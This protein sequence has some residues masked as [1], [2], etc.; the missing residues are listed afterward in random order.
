MNKRK[1]I[2][3]VILIF[4]IMIL[5]EA[6]YAYRNQWV[7]YSYFLNVA[8]FFN[9]N[10]GCTRCAFFII[11]QGKIEYPGDKQFED[12]VQNR[13]A[14]LPKEYN[15][16]AAI[17]SLALDAYE[18]GNAGLTEKML[19]ESIRLDPDFSFWYVEL[20]NFYLTQGDAQKAA[21][22]MDKCLKLS[23]PRKHC[24]SYIDN[25][26]IY[27]QPQSV[28]YLNDTIRMLYVEKGLQ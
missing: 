25:F 1:I 15:L 2:V 16:P 3:G 20:A 18:S 5:S 10:I 27:N 11:T 9:N 4:F 19:W 12:K 28:G 7:R 13:I 21:F 6:L 22:I 17:Y 24:Q 8:R 26:L 23:A 14:S